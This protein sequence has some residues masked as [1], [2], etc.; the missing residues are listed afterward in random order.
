[1]FFDTL[2]DNTDLFVDA[3]RTTIS[4]AVVTAV[5]CIVG[6]TVLAAMRVSPVPVLRASAWC[7]STSSATRH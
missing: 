2:F 1:M 4:L 5:L 3:F 6:G 7:T